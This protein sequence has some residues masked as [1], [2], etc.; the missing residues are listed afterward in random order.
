MSIERC[1]VVS[2]KA[3][4]FFSSSLWIFSELCISIHVKLKIYYL[5]CYR[6]HTYFFFH[7]PR[8]DVARWLLGEF[9]D[10][11]RIEIYICFL[12]SVKPR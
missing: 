4:R 2:T 10:Q 6:L 7:L 8:S 1:V 5:R 3:M 9:I 12:F 11:T